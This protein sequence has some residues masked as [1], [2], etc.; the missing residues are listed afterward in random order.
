MKKTFMVLVSIA[1][2]AMFVTSALAIDRAPKKSESDSTTEIKEM[3]KEKA[4]A[5]NEPRKST[6]SEK[7]LPQGESPK[8]AVGEK[9]EKPKEKPEAIR[10]KEK[11]DYFI[12]SNNNGIDDR[13]EK[14]VKTKSVQKPKSVKKQEI[15]KKQVPAP[16]EKKPTAVSPLPKAPEKKEV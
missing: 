1:A 8:T 14:D 6:F 11:Y 16:V 2:V 3:T 15:I 5:K 4:K 12:D 10:G 7:T 9:S 13:L